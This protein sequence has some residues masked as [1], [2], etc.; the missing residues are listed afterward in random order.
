M[1]LNSISWKSNSRNEGNRVRR[2]IEGGGRRKSKGKGGWGRGG[3]W[4]MEKGKGGC[5]ELCRKR[6]L[7]EGIGGE[8]MKRRE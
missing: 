5:G 4:K 8:D 6:D 7:L 3:G 2:G 1:I